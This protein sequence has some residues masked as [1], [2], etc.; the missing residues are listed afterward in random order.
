MTGPAESTV[1]L[2]YSQAEAPAD[3]AGSACP[4]GENADL[5]FSC[6]IEKHGVF[7]NSPG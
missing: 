3:A 7:M 4:K 1:S 2:D 5:G 6:V